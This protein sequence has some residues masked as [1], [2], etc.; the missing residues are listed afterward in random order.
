[1]DLGLRNRSALVLGGSSGIGYAI[2]E[3]L[4]R[5]GASVTIVSRTE[6]KLKAA[7]EKL[8]TATGNNHV[9]FRVADVLH[10]K[11]LSEMWSSLGAKTP[12]ILVHNSGG[13]ATG[14]ASEISLEKW[15]EGYRL[16]LRSCVQLSQLALPAMK[17]REWGR[18]LVVTSTTSRELIPNLPVSGVYRA[19]LSA[20]V[21]S[22]AREVGK[23]NVL[24]NNLLPG[25]TN[26][27][28]LSHLKTDAPKFFESMKEE[29]ALKRLA[30]ADEIG[31]VGAFLVSQANTYITGT[32]ILADGGYTKAY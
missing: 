21:K 17:S 1:M 15:D 29:T 18:I 27:E 31:R 6:A 23:W 22:F 11:S 4:L 10:E 25:P 7:I 3:Q 24:A 20:W 2:A 16:L 28:R 30:E 8:A 9:H 14:L 5:E 26:T 13:P 12:D 32:D 19:G